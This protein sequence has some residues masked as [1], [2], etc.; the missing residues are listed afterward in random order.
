MK[1][2]IRVGSQRLVATIC[3]GPTCRPW[4]RVSSSVPTVIANSRTGNAQITSMSR[5]SSESVTPPKKPAI[6]A[7]T[8]AMRQQMTAEP[9]PMSSELRPP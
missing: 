3:S 1:A 6:S 2:M 9:I 8:V 5:E 4:G 7:S